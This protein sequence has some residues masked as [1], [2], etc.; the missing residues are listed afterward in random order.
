MF[1][2]YL[3]IAHDCIFLN[4]LSNSK[5]STIPVEKETSF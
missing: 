3:K 4:I 5:F 2:A 1:G